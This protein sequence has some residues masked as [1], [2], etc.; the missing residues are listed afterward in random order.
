MK[1]DLGKLKSFSFRPPS[2]MVELEALRVLAE[3]Y[4]KAKNKIRIYV[5]PDP[6]SLRVRV[7]VRMTNPRIILMDE[8]LPLQSVADAEEVIHRLRSEFAAV[9]A[10]ED[11]KNEGDER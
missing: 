5:G 2:S 7:M 9:E 4:P 8:L 3:C 10:E 6:V 1:W 11:M